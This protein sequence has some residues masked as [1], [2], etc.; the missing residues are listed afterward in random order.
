VA[1]RDRAPLRIIQLQPGIDRRIQ[2][3]QRCHDSK[4]SGFRGE[5]EA[6]ALLSWAAFNRITELVL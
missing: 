1:V 2:I 3:E 6:N 4:G 5:E